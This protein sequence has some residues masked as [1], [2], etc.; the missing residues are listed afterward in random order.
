MPN[1]QN[2]YQWLESNPTNKQGLEWNWFEGDDRID[3][4]GIAIGKDELPPF[5]NHL[6][7]EEEERWEFIQLGQNHNL[8]PYL[9]VI[10][11]YH[12]ERERERERDNY[13]KPCQPVAIVP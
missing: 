10:K 11:Q 7:I 5:F 6:L 1:L 13:I 3:M 9:E 8:V 4:T 2:F 12:Q